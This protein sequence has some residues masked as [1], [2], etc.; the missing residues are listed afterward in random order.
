MTPLARPMRALLLLAAVL[1][2]LAGFQLTVFPTRTADWFAWTIDVPMTAVFLGAAYWSSAVLEVSGARSETWGRARLAVWTVLVFTTLTLVVTLVHLDRF[3]LGGAHAVGARA[4]AW[5]WLAIYAGVPVA[6]LAG[7]VLQSRVPRGRGDRARR[8]LPPLL[9]GLLVGL[10]A[11]LLGCGSVLLLA[12]EWA[13]QG[14]AWQL[15]PL[16][17][18]AVGAWLVGLGWAAAHACLADDAADVRPIAL[19]GAAFVVLESVALLRHGDALDWSSGRS[20]AYLA[21]L[22]WIAVVSAWMLRLRAAGAAAPGS[23]R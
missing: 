3:H 17:A 4:V 12:P 16:T 7:T 20:A 15:T 2:F 18:R 6:M 11:V 14:W 13:A 19:T 5:G 23:S 10:S 22:T 9:R 8:P 21:G 1:V